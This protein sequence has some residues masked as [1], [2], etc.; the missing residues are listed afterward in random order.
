MK[1]GDDEVVGA[2]VVAPHAGDLVAQVT[3]A[4]ATG[5]GLGALSGVVVPYPSVAEALRKAADAHRRTKLTDR[6][7]RGFRW[8]F[9]VRRHLT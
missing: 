9:R 5:I 7:H 4:M 6:G 3:Q 1:T 2:T 8:F